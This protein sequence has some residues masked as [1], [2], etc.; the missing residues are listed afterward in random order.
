[1]A[2]RIFR[3]PRKTTAFLHDV[4]MAALSFFVALGLRLGD[5]A[6]QRIV[7]DLWLPLIIF[8]AVCALVFWFTGLYRGIWR[9]A[10]LDDMI[11]IARAVTLALLIYL[12]VTFMLTRLDAVPRSM[13]VINWFVLAFLL[14][15]PRVIYRVFK[16]QG[17][18]HLLER[19]AHTRVPVLVIGANDAAE[20]FIREMARDP[21]APYEVLGLVDVKGTRVGRQI[22]GQQVLGRLDELPQILKQVG[23]NV[24]TPQRLILASR[25]ERDE[26][27]RLLDLAEEQGMT[28]ARLPRLTELESGSG[29][30]IQVQPVAIEDLL[31]RVQT[32]LDR[33]DMGRLI[34]GRRVLVT[35]AGGSIGSELVRQI[36]DFRP[37]HLTLL[38][39]AE[40]LLYEID[41]ELGEQHPAQSRDTVL[42]DIRDRERLIR[43][44]TQMAPDLVFHAAA[45]KQIPLVEA[46]PIEGVVTNVAGTRNTADACRKAG[47]AGMVL[48]SSDKA[49]NPSSVMGAT[50]RLAES[51]C[52]ALDLAEGGQGAGTRFVTVRFGNVLGS[53]GSVV[54]LFQRQLAA[55]GPLTVTD[56][57]MERYFMTVREAVE[58]VLQASALGMEGGRDDSGKIY[59]LNMGEPVKIT[60][61]ARQMIR[62]A[63]LRPE[64]DVKIVYTGL[65]PGEKLTEELFHDHESL[66]AT[67]HPGL[68]LAAPRSTNLE[69]LIRGLDE[70]AERAATGQ[71]QEVLDLLQRLVPEYQ[72]ATAKAR[73]AS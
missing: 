70:L 25:L 58:L 29:D 52:Q 65:R 14:S 60:E 24:R 54:P 6:W 12:P 13:L 48:I 72:P 71:R 36:A 67:R 55:G 5:E 37:A 32:K 10:S 66:V 20:V 19:G 21:A 16:D 7:D 50:K 42:A 23:T 30:S 35:G 63:G 47:V 44:F 34:E 64:K 2:L 26:I 18:Q 17:L 31:G 57:A 8:T 11:A 28:L 49:I 53:T 3:L 56:P 41:L 9:Y 68:L 27:Q 43:L 39:N 51:Y 40:G 38:D 4:F 33:G 61:L 59:L 69:L 45:F 1:M 73:A 62:L 15:A 22:R 46:N